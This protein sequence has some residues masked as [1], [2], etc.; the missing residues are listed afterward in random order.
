M[1]MIALTSH[2]YTSPSTRKPPRPAHMSYSSEKTAGMSEAHA[3]DRHLH[4]Q[5]ENNLKV[6]KVYIFKT[7]GKAHLFWSIVLTVITVVVSIGLGFLWRLPEV[8]AVVPLDLT[9]SDTP[10]V[11]IFRC[12]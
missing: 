6:R 2:L 3:E 10:R 1:A 4:L 7:P 8:D 11:S 9:F 5:T 12:F